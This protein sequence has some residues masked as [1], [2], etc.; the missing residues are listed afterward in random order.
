MVNHSY[1]KVN[2]TVYDQVGRP[3]GMS[4]CPQT[5]TEG[6]VI[7]IHLVCFVLRI[8]IYS[9][10]SKAMVMLIVAHQYYESHLLDHTTFHTG[11]PFNFSIPTTLI[12][13]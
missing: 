1:L 10:Q 13:D 12:D 9:D 6:L 2:G 8:A 4:P 11:Y 3:L 7:L 5:G